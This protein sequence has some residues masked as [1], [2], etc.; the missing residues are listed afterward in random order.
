MA[1][2]NEDTRGDLSK[3]MRHTSGNDWHARGA[4]KLQLDC[5][6]DGGET[7]ED[8]KDCRRS[9]PSGPR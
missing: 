2:T 9:V 5:Q 8:K 7:E 3:T 1:S 6:C 4:M